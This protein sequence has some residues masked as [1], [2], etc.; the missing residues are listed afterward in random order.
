MAKPR[1]W[2]KLKERFEPFVDPTYREK[3]DENRAKFAHLFLGDLKD[4]YAKSRLERD[5]LE[6]QVSKINIDLMALSQLLVE[7][8][9]ANGL[10]SIST[11]AGHVIGTTVE[12]QITPE[13]L[14][15]FEEWVSADPSL[16]YVWSVNPMTRQ[17]MVKA[18]LDDG[19]DE[20]LPPGLKITLKTTIHFTKAH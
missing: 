15:K 2:D 19:D 13:D 12:P 18:I 1:R 8:L 5:D 7:H 10:R 16:D 4:E 14:G 17:S 20:K 11:D 3:V 6:D 9:E